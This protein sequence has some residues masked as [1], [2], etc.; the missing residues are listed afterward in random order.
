[1]VLT[2]L[3]LNNGSINLVACMN[4]LNFNLQ[5]VQKLGFLKYFNFQFQYTDRK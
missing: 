1:M 2:D 5:V 4:N 3:S